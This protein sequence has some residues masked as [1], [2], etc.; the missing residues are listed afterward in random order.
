M[1]EDVTRALALALL[2]LLVLPSALAHIQGARPVLQRIERDR[3]VDLQPDGLRLH[4][5]LLLSTEPLRNLVEHDIDPAR[6]RFR[7]AHREDAALASGNF[8]STW[9]VQ[10]LVEFR[11]ANANGRFE[12]EIDTAVKAWR[13][14]HYQWRLSAV[15]RVEVGGVTATS[16]VWEANLTSAP[17]IRLEVV[18]A[19]LAFQDE[20][21]TVRPQD[22][23]IYLDFLNMPPRSVGSLYALDV[24]AS[25][26]AASAFRMHAADNTSTAHLSEADDRLA[27]F[28]WGGEALVDGTEVRLDTLLADEDVDEAGNR[29]ARLTLH[30]PTTD[31]SIRYVLVSGIEY[32]QEA[33]RT[34][35]LWWA[36]LVAAV[37]ISLAARA[38]RA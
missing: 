5:D 19:G 31:E 7:V 30:M 11:D 33:E 27:F 26:P 20:G 3:I 34:P 8:E 9:E 29:T 25:A 23:A 28:V 16:S 37:A 2:A 38:R 36:P 22:I 12:S 35:A 32:V 4:A 1:A 18:L 24:H 6:G 17:D 13:L 15:Q 10:R 14:T 21:A